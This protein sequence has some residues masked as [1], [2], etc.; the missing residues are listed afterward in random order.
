MVKILEA[1]T[2]IQFAQARLLFE[3]YAE[4]LNLD[5]SFQ[6][7]SEEIENIQKQYSR[8]EGVVYIVYDSKGVPVGCVGVRSLEGDICELKRMYLRDSS[9]GRGIGNQMLRQAIDAGIRLGY[10]KM[11]LDTLPTML[12]AV[13]LY[14]KFGFY[15]I[16]PYRHNPVYN[17]KYFEIELKEN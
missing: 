16:E 13:K 12:S 10:K 4:E 14:E 17:A 2:D 7:F 3:E 6:N 8:P 15:E 5:L 9:R 1:K 11:R